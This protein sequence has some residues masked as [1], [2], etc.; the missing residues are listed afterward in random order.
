MPKD[1][2]TRF[3]DNFS[4]LLGA[5][6]LT[7]QKAAPLL[8]VSPASISYWLNGH[9]EPDVDS[10]IAIERYFGVNTFDIMTYPAD[11]FLFGAFGESDRFAI[12]EQRIAEGVT[13]AD[14][15]RAELAK[16]GKQMKTDHLDELEKT[17]ERVAVSRRERGARK[18]QAVDGP[19]KP[20]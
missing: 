7:A 9:R 17:A 4:R 6:R 14:L 2:A 18:L 5:H 1:Q 16:A 12:V 11:L 19:K 3:A 20:A 13:V 15:E 8:G 10:L